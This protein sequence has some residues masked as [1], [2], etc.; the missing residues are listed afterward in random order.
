MPATPAQGSPGRP[1]TASKLPSLLSL[2][3][4]LQAGWA[5]AAWLRLANLSQDSASLA[6]PDHGESGQHLQLG[7]PGYLPVQKEDPGA[8][9]GHS[10]VPWQGRE[11]VLGK[12]GTQSCS[13][14]T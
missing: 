2:G 14:P 7:S 4:I 13:P 3:R 8:N 11:W 5:G 1:D 9:P 10:L 12:G 6:S